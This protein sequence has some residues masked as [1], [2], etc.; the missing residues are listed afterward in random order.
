MTLQNCTILFGSDDSLVYLSSS[1]RPYKIKLTSFRETTAYFGHD[2][3]FSGV[4]TAVLSERQI[5]VIGNDCYFSNEIWVKTSDSC[6][7]YSTDTRERLNPSGSIFIG[8]HVLI[9]QN[10]LVKKGTVVGS[11]A[12]LTDR[13]V[14]TDE[15]VPSNTLWGGSPAA[16]LQNGVFFDLV[17]T[18]NWG[19]KEINSHQILDTREFTFKEDDVP[20]PSLDKIDILLRSQVTVDDRLEQL[21]LQLCENTGKNRFFI[22]YVAPA[23]VKEEKSSSPWKKLFKRKKK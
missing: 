22:P 14:I 13:I 3:Y 12:I 21:R 9:E 16:L 18:H 11:G 10:A 8:D 7:I 2:C 6:P 4:L 1:K 23:V 19:Y 17:G 5:V 15:V 20:H